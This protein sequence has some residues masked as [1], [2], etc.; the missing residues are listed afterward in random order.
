MNTEQGSQTIDHF[1][2]LHGQA[3]AQQAC[4]VHRRET[5]NC[6]K[7]LPSQRRNFYK[8]SLVN[9]GQG[10]LYYG[11]QCLQVRDHS[12]IFFNPNTPYSWFADTSQ[13]TGYFLTFDGAFLATNRQTNLLNAAPFRNDD[14]PVYAYSPEQAP[15]LAFLFEQLL[16]EQGNETLAKQAELQNYVELIIL[17]GLK[18]RPLIEK[19]D[20]AAPV[21]ISAQFITL[22]QQQFN[23]QNKLFSPLDYADEL[24]IHVNHLNRWV[25]S[26]TGK[27]TQQHINQ[28]KILEARSQLLQTDARISEVAYKLGFNHPSSFNHFFK[29]HQGISPKLFR[30]NHV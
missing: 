14:C 26:A 16:S 1:Y 22:L 7:A 27:T 13:Q 2:A 9:Q 29:K 19:A 11:D 8:I 24:S 15:L 5:F 20:R 21:R 25:K 30:H 18:A 3:S 23:P 10:V 12:L 28:Q 17:Q 4:Q 6:D